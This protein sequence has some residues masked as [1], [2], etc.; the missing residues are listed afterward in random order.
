MKH[1][2]KPTNFDVENTDLIKAKMGKLLTRWACRFYYPD[3]VLLALEAFANFK[4][5]KPYVSILTYFC[6]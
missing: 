5:G 3:C 4:D 1:L 6:S 2:I